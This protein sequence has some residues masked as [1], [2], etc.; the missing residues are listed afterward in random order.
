MEKQDSFLMK[1]I[2]TN[3]KMLRTKAKISQDDF[4]DMVDL[5]RVSISN[6]ESGRQGTTCLFL[7]KS[8]KIFKCNIADL[9][10]TD[11]DVR[12]GNVKSDARID[13]KIINLQNRVD[14]L[15]RL[16]EANNG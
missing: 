2:G 7:L 14:R 16:K 9:V 6:I 11:Y 4:A 3:V 8:C 10:P 12:I 5:N 15:K 13:K 1:I